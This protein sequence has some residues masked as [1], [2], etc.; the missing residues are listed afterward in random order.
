MLV[1]WVLCNAASVFFCL[2]ASCDLTKSPIASECCFLFIAHFST[3]KISLS[4]QTILARVLCTLNGKGAPNNPL[5]IAKWPL[6]VCSTFWPHVFHLLVVHRLFLYFYPKQQ[7]RKKTASQTF[8][9]IFGPFCQ[10]S[11]PG[12][13]SRIT[14]YC[15]YSRR[16]PP[17]SGA[18][19]R[20]HL[21]FFSFEN[22]FRRLCKEKIYPREI[23][24]PKYA[25]FF[26][27]SVEQTP[28][29]AVFAG[30]VEIFEGKSARDAKIR[31]KMLAN[32]G[33]LL[34]CEH[35]ERMHWK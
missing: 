19:V 22:L 18:L 8:V 28:K 24:A 12:F 4:L 9:F 7:I 16:T 31:M 17:K 1:A 2:A 11:S 29:V 21:G 30:I 3:G 23:W 14:L 10:P 34:P 6:K 20:G 26:L 25:W 13:F 27:Q 15:F 35:S 32:V 5:T 33:L